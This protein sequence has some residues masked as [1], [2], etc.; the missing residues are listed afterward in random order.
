VP[1][2]YLLLPLFAAIVYSLGSIV[3]KRALKEG[4]TMDQSFHLTNLGLGVLFL[5]LIFLEKTAIDWSQVAKPALIGAAF[6]FGHWLTFIALRRGDVSFVTPLMGTKVVF[7][8]LGV[9]FLTG[10]TPSVPLLVAAV[11]TTIGIFVMGLGDLKGGTHLAHTVVVTLASALLFGLFDVLVVWWAAD[12]GALGFLGIGMGTVP[13]FTFALW[14]FQ[15]RPS[16]TLPKS[17][18]SWTWWGAILIALQAI[19]MGIGLSYFDDATGVNVV[20]AS[21]GLWVIV[22]LVVFGRI[23]GNSERHDTG[24]GFLWRV[25][26]T[27]I[28]TIAIVI[29]VA[30]RAAATAS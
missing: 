18:V 22:L 10:K 26:G 11:L 4:V 8:A 12:F 5:P 3:I 24:R 14:L 21:R 13:F 29:A 9:V 28:L 27:I 2:L 19:I 15:G 7:V 20:Y 6:F 23:L 1:P 30:D 16:L 17:G 25:L